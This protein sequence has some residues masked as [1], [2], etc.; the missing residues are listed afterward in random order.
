M[1]LTLGP[2]ANRAI[3]REDPARRLGVCLLMPGDALAEES[4]AASDRDAA[5]PQN[6]PGPVHAE[7]RCWLGFPQLNE[8]PIIM[9]NVRLS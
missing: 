2:E 1:P 4:Q 6:T 3:R 7:N 8:W 9:G 5:W